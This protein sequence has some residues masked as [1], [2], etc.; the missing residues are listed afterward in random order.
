MRATHE[1]SVSSTEAPQGDNA[2]TGSIKS[3]HTAVGRDKLC[4]GTNRASA[5][6]PG[7]DPRIFGFQEF[8]AWNC[9]NHARHSNNAVAT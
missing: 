2:F 5:A 6:C 7:K 9:F 4:A 8:F 1:T 3:Q